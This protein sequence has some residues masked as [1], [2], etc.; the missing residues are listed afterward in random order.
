MTSRK[1]HVRAHNP[2]FVLDVPLKV[3]LGISGV[4]FDHPV[5]LPIDTG[6]NLLSRIAPDEAGMTLGNSGLLDSML[7]GPSPGVADILWLAQEDGTF[8]RYYIAD[9]GLGGFGWRRLGNPVQDASNVLLTRAF[10]LQR[11]G[12]PT[13]V[14]LLV[15]PAQN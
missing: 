12:D 6:F 13:T 10:F 15:E 2:K 11:R 4:F 9:G 14:R 8:V 7:R 1:G 5:V 3:L